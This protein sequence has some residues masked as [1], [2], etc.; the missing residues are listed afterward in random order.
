[1]FLIFAKYADP[2]FLANELA[3]FIKRVKK[4]N[5]FLSDVNK[6]LRLIPVKRGFA[7]KIAIIGRINGATKTRMFSLTKFK[8][9]KSNQNFTKNINFAMAHAKTHIGIF[10]IKI[11][12][13]Y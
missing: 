4:Q 2:Q 6:I 10:G 5:W 3:K 8:Q 1:V 13:Y 12:V 7:Y 9:Y 11:W